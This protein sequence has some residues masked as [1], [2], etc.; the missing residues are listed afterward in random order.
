MFL[1]CSTCSC[2]PPAPA[3]AHV[4]APLTEV[5]RTRYGARCFPYYPCFLTAT[6][7]PHEE[8]VLSAVRSDAG[9]RE[10]PAVM[11]PQLPGAA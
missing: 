1:C 10:S 9:P 6:P 3:G 7:V 11:L 8:H 4:S 2:P 5:A